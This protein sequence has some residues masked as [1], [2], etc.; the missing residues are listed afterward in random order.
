MHLKTFRQKNTVSQGKFGN[1]GLAMF[2]RRFSK[3]GQVKLDPDPTPM[4]ANVGSGAGALHWL[5]GWTF[6][7]TIY[8]PGTCLSSILGRNNP[9]T[10]G[11]FQ[12]KQG[13]FGFQVG[14]GFDIF[15][16]FHPENWGRWTHFD[17]HIF[18]MG[19]NHQADLFFWDGTSSQILFRFVNG[20]PPLQTDVAMENPSF[21][22]VSAIETSDVP[23]PC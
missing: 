13:S 9:P 11:L 4:E 3:M 6:L 14:G 23:L 1:P 15:F 2:P 12:S 10:Q 21:E 7:R 16:Y 17:E 19:W 18:Q 20:Y 22:D 8:P 5:I